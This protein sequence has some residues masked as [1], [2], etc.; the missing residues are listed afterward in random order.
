MFWSAT[1]SLHSSSDLCSNCETSLAINLLLFAT[2]G[3]KLKI[4]SFPLHAI[5]LKADHKDGISRPLLYLLEK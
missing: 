1:D 4:Q 5:K 3:R 2:K